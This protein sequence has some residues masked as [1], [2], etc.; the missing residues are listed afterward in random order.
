MSEKRRAL[1]RGL[2]ALIP[3]APTSPNGRPV[4][5]FFPDSR[6]GAATAYAGGSR[7]ADQDQG[8]GV[9]QADPDAVD[10]TI[11][12]ATTDGAAE[13]GSAAPVAE[14]GDQDVREAAGDEGSDLAP[15]PGVSYGEIPVEQI[16]PNPRQ[17]RSVFDEDDMAELVHSI[18][19]IG[20]LQPIVIRPIPAGQGPDELDNA[21][22]GVRYELI[23]G[24]RRWR[25]SQEAGKATV[26]AIVKETEDDDLLRDA[27][28]ENLHRSQLNPLEEAAAYSQLLEDFGC[29]HDELAGRIGRSRPQISNTIRLLKLPPLVARRVAAGVLSAGHARALLGLADG[30]A[31]ERVAQRIVAE[32]LSVRNVEEIVAV[33]GPDEV[34]KPRRPRAGSRHP[35]LDDLAAR[36]SDRFD[37]RVNIALGQRK[38]KLTVEFASVEDLNRIVDM[39]GLDRS[40]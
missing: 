27:L 15:V 3:N 12:T 14:D 22:D 13:T 2:G 11:A 16:R 6:P 9:T 30:A 4:D 5:V 39:L 37:T 31:M 21:A 36:L 38:G 17:P 8:G 10:G 1:G 40:A 28:L 18:R 29:T 33:G 26:P 20:V 25:A 24:E 32:G 35:Q 7:G 23:M 34:A 19:E